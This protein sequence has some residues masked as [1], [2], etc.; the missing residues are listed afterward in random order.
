[1]LRIKHIQCWCSFYLRGLITLP[2]FI[3]IFGTVVT[4]RNV[5]CGYCKC[6]LRVLQMWIAGTVNAIGHQWVLC[7]CIA[8]VFIT[9]GIDGRIL[10]TW[11]IRC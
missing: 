11:E 6:G 2:L 1:M 3:Y 10:L 7:V 5:D 8:E 9:L 4:E